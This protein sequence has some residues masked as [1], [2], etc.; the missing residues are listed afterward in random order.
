[1]KALEGILTNL[2]PKEY[3]R[4]H[5]PTNH[6]QAIEAAPLQGRFK[7]W[8]LQ[9]VLLPR[10]L[11]P[12]TIYEIGLSV[13]EDL[14]RKVNRYTKGLPSALSSVSLYSRSACLR[15][16]LRSIVEEYKLSK[17]RTQ[18]NAQ[19]YHGQQDPRGQATAQ[20]WKEI[21]SAERGRRIS[22]LANV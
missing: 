21:P 10:L 14:K 19:Q 11:W 1:M 15:L 18:W 9:F 5:I 3:E 6:L 8:L 20:I 4:R 13:V 16:P 22:S 7:V 2:S 12:L 17:I